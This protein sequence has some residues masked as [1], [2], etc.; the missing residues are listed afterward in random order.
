MCRPLQTRDACISKPIVGVSC[1]GVCLKILQVFL[2]LDWNEKKI[3]GQVDSQMKGKYAPAKQTAGFRDKD[4]RG[5]GYCYIYNTEPVGTAWFTHLRIKQDASAV[6]DTKALDARRALDVMLRK[7]QV[8][9]W[10][11]QDMEVGMKM[12]AI[13]STKGSGMNLAEEQRANN[14]MGVR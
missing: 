12:G 10:V 13:S 4:C 2:K 11:Q 6:L 8:D 3:V 1:Y 7:R 9:K 14:N 5:F